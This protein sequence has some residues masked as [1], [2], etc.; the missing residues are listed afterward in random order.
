MLPPETNSTGTPAPHTREERPCV[1]STAGTWG[2]V[3]CPKRTPDAQGRGNSHCACWW[4]APACC[5]LCGEVCRGVSPALDAL[6]HANGQQAQRIAAQD[7]ELAELRLEVD[8]LRERK[9]G[10]YLERNR[11]V[12]LLARM[13]VG[14]GWRAGV[15]EHPA[16]D[17]AWEPDW[18]TLVFIDLPTGQVS[19]HFHDS[20]KG[21]LG[22]LPRYHGAWDGHTT[23]EKYRRVAAVERARVV[24]SNVAFDLVGERV[25]LQPATCPRCKGSGRVA[26][27]LPPHPSGAIPRGIHF[28]PCPLCAAHSEGSKTP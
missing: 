8:R 23:E 14:L 17:T 13:A 19:W 21:L 4:S 6:A 15:R 5:C 10:A 20:Q 3:A 24:L 16:E 22:G 25:E 26:E 9:D 11:C 1:A 18:R 28:V 12:A 2:N 27:S 7:A